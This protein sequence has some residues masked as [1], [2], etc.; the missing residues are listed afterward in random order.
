MY[1][2]L[3]LGL[4]LLAAAPAAHAQ[5]APPAGTEAPQ[6]A[7]AM[8]LSRMLNPEDKILGASDHAFKTGFTSALAKDADT[9]ALFDQHPKLL[10]TIFDAAIPVVRKHIGARVPEL[11]RKCARF[12]ADKFT[13]AEIDQLIAFYGSPTGA[14]LVAGMYAGLDMEKMVEAVGPDGTAPV[15]PEAMRGVLTSTA[16]RVLPA[17]D[18]AD[19]TAFLQF[20]KTPL[21]AK[22][23]AATPDMIKLMTEIANK[24]SP[25]M[26]AEVE[27]V[28]GRVVT[29][30][31][32]AAKDAATTS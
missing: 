4:A 9:A 31:F 26:D 15:T 8:Q 20:S 10:D 22:V 6:P 14:K 18:K 27:Q 13:A 17:F 30:Y 29:D 11:Q 12:Y 25:E 2:H 1:R 19:W 5:P 3:M 7:N 32:V 28:I 21:F 23:R 24:P 16:M